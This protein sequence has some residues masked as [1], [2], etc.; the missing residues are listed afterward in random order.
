MAKTPR[1]K[2]VKKVTKKT[3]V[4]SKKEKL[5]ELLSQLDDNDILLF[6]N[7]L[8]VDSNNDKVETTP[9]EDIVAQP[10]VPNTRKEAIPSSIKLGNRPNKFDE[11][12]K[13]PR[14]AKVVHAQ[15]KKDE[16]SLSGK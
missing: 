9:K 13:N 16:E 2:V 12:M 10:K 11:M 5:I 4:K 7:L 6:K 3:P 14:F 1:K 15:I 8:S